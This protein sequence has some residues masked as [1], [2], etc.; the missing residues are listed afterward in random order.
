[1][2]ASDFTFDIA[3]ENEFVECFK[4]Y[5]VVIVSNVMTKAECKET[6]LDIGLPKDCNIM[7]PK[8]Y[9]NFDSVVNKYG[10]LNSNTVLFSKSVLRNRTN[11]NVKKVFELLYE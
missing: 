4:K 10:I 7:D 3:Q 8:T 11:Q 9:T 5:G 6:F 2:D 1:M